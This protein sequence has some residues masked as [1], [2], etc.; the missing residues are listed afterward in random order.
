MSGAGF[1]LAINLFVAALFS[2]A[3]FLVAA[4]NKSDRVAIWF[5][6]AYLCGVGYFVFEFLL[7]FQASPKITG[8]AAF[9]SFL[10]ALTTITV[11][12]ARRYQVPVPWW[13][14][15]VSVALFLIVNWFAF[16]LPRDS[17]LRMLIYQAPYAAMQAVCAAIVIQS[18]RRQ[19]MDIGLLVLFTL[20][21]LQF[22]SKP[23]VAQLTGGPGASAQEYIGT[24]Y[25]LYSQSLGAVLSVGTGLLM[26][27]ILVRDMLE[28]VTTRS[29]TDS[30]SGL[31]NRRGFEDRVEP[32]LIATSRGGVPAAFI[33]ADL[34]HFKG[35][36]DSYGHEVGDKVIQSFAGLLRSSAPA[37]STA[38]RIGGEEFAVFLPG[39]NLGAARLYAEGVRASFALFSVEGVPD[40]VHFTVSFGVAESDGSESLAELRRRADAALYAAK[41]GGRNRVCVANGAGIDAMPAHPLSSEA[42]RRR[43]AG[44]S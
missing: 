13:L 20:S 29:E 32:G 18:R 4:N 36:N 19:A 22:L 35:I 6:L 34:D 26:L 9:A 24:N 25:A 5:G 7:P 15:G 42:P 23:F 2:V 39:S 8:F 33:A 3:F 16:D 37:R 30:L 31:L 40:D 17:V 38:A 43:P 21:A 14:V 28:T 10:A 41:K 44:F 27:M 11:G 1:I 12:I